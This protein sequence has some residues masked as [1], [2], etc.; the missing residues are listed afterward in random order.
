M[1]KTALALIFAVCHCWK[2]FNVPA[3]SFKFKTE[4]GV[5]FIHSC[6]PPPPFKTAG[7]LETA[8]EFHTLKN[9]FFSLGLSN[10]E[11]GKGKPSRTYSKI[12]IPLL[13]VLTEAKLNRTRMQ[14]FP[15]TCEKV[16]QSLSSTEPGAFVH[17]KCKKDNMRDEYTAAL[18]HF[19]QSH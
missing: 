19:H 14:M 17:L 16:I 7:K 11:Q 8:A 3:L 18:Q 10:T 15:E 9:C 13:K 12:Q 1:L 4:S 5:L 2:K 6:D